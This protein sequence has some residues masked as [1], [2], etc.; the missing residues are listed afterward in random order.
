MGWG[1]FVCGIFVVE[2]EWKFFCGFDVDWWWVGLVMFVYFFVFV[3][4]LIVDCCLYFKI[5]VVCV[6]Y[7]CGR[8]EFG[9]VEEFDVGGVGGIDLV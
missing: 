1:F 5:D 6:L 9:G 4:W 8:F 2:V 3:G 7:F